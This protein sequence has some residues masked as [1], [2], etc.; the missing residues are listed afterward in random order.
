MMRQGQARL[1]Y[2][3]PERLSNPRFQQALQNYPPAMVVVDEAHCVVQWGKDF[4]PDYQRIPDFIR[5]L[6]RVPV[7]CAFTATADARL[8]R[9]LCHALGLRRPRVVIQPL[10]RAN[11]HYHA[12]LTSD[13]ESWL[14]RYVQARAGEKGIIFCR[15]RADTERMASVLQAHG[16]PAAAYHAGLPDD[17]R[18]R[19]QDYFARGELKTLTATSAFGMGVDIPDIRYVVHLGLCSSPL[20]Y[21]QQAGRAGRDGMASACVQLITPA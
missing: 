5:E 18:T 20:D 19:N 8:Q 10:E 14:L 7:V 1:I 6:P 12:I 11:L 13:A 4:R 21:I 15:T 3:A 17:K 16:I 2:V 9:E